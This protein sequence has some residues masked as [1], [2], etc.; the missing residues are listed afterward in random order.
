MINVKPRSARLAGNFDMTNSALNVLKETIASVPFHQWLRPE[1]VEADQAAG[2]AVIA[3]A[4]RAEFLRDAKTVHGG[5][6]AA[7]IDIAGH[8]AVAAS[9]GR[10]APTIDLRVDYLRLA[11]GKSLLAT[12]EALKVGRSV[13]VVDIRVAD[14]Q[15][16]VVAVGRCVFSTQDPRS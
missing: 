9:L 8:A 5:V 7:L 10:G 2:R 15:N 13:G 14:D 12:A 1:L 4:I 3:L 11:F 6:I 16:R